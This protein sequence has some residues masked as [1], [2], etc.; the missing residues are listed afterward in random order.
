VWLDESAQETGR[1]GGCALGG[2]MV[3]VGCRIR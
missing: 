1:L 2:L 3:D